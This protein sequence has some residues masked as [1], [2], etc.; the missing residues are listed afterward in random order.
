MSEKSFE[1]RWSD[2]ERAYGS[3][4]PG[5][6]S[7]E[8]L[9]LLREAD[10]KIENKDKVIDEL[11]KHSLEIVAMLR[12]KERRI[13]ELESAVKI[14]RSKYYNLAYAPLQPIPEDKGENNEND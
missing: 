5:V 8:A 4:V 13:E 9:K 12:R 7:G 1:R 6:V 3:S 11:N 10:A 2:Q 14:W